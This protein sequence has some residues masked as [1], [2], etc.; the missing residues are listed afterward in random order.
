L[1]ARDE[2]AADKLECIGRE[3]F[4][5]ADAEDI[6]ALLQLANLLGLTSSKQNC[7]WTVT[8]EGRGFSQLK[9]WRFWQPPPNIECGAF[10][11][12]PEEEPE[13]RPAVIDLFCGAGGFS[14]G[15]ESAG[16]SIRWAIDD[17]PLACE[18]FK[19]NFP[20]CRVVQGDI[21]VI[22]PTLEKGSL[23]KLGV[24]PDRLWGIIGGPPCQS[25][26]G[27]GERNP[28][29][30]RS[31][32]VNIFMEVVAKLEPAFFVMENVPGLISIGRDSSLAQVLK[33]KAKS[34]GTLAMKI[35]DALPP[36]SSKGIEA[37]PRH[38]R[39]RKR[40]VA[41]AIRNFRKRLDEEDG[42]Y[43]KP[44]SH[45]AETAYRILQ[46]VLEN[47]VVVNIILPWLLLH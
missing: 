32:F 2:F 3:V 38:D 31:S 24:E 25:F 8:E 15:F 18:S 20:Q 47:H 1:R 40:I 23:P 45:K 44:W 11:L 10:F 28:E 33:M 19:T 27:I 21:R 36:V 37:V 6:R 7:A 14:L 41:E 26:S 12:S 22:A 5:T 29:D 39:K 30:N 17:D 9:H 4:K 46:E 42:G 43:D 16:F 35:A 13:K 34:V